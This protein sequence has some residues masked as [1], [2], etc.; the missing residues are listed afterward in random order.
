MELF[1]SFL[2]LKNSGS[3]LLL[4]DKNI[5]FILFYKR[6]SHSDLK[7]DESEEIMA[8]LPFWVNYAI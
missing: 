2:K 3:H 4:L 6:K 5:K 7:Y 8:E 1:A